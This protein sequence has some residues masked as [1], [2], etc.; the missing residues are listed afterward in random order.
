MLESSVTVFKLTSLGN[1]CCVLLSDQYKDLKERGVDLVSFSRRL[2]DKNVGI[3][4]DN[5]LVV[6]EER[7][8]DKGRKEGKLE[9]YNAD[10]SA[11]GM[12][13]NGVRCVAYLLTRLEESNRSSVRYLFTLGKRQVETV[14]L[15]EEESV[16]INL[17]KPIFD[18]EGVP[19]NIEEARRNN[20]S[21]KVSDVVSYEFTPVGM[22]NPHCVIEV[23]RVDDINLSFEGSFIERSVDIFP[24]KTNVEFVEPKAPYKVRIWERGVGET[25]SSGSG[26]SAVYAAL[27]KRGRINAGE[28]VSLSMKGGDITVWQDEQGSIWTESPVSFIATIDLSLSIVS[29]SL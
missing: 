2:L 12:C 11:V 22:G 9:G 1:S 28:E 16:A 5:L 19:F 6:T 23:D 29:N 4:A 18:P 3:G 8:I 7:D 21:V 17:G 15:R 14:V 25:L 24:Q 26:A 27:V 10:G 13:G 20:F